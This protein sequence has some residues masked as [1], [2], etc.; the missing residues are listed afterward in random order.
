MTRTILDEPVLVLNVNYEPL[1]VCHTKRAISL[2]FTDKADIILNGR[3]KVRSGSAE[4]DLPSV[5]R[6]RYMVKRPRPH[7]T[8]SKREVL[9]RDNFTCQYCGRK[10]SVLTID[11]VK[12]RHMGGS[13]SWENLVAA[14]ASCNRRKGGM[15]VAKANMQLLREPFEPS[16]SAKYLFGRYLTNHT[17]WTQFI[18]GW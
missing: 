11:H 3:G 18:D 8:L 14:C 4:F 7:V 13:H 17:E 6:L 9:R 12:P 5:I 1:N 2:L 16:A 15:L 10:S